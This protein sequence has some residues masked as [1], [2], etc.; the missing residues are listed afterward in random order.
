MRFRE[1]ILCDLNRS[2]QSLKR[3]E[4]FQF[5][6]ALRQVTPSVIGIE[7]LPEGQKDEACT[8]DF[9]AFLN[10]D[11]LQYQRTL[12]VQR[13]QRNP[14]A[15]FL[16]L[17]YHIVWN[18]P[19]RKPVFAHPA[20]EINILQDAFS[21][22]T[23]LVGGFVSLLWLAPDHIHLYVESDGKNSIDAVARKLKRVS[24]TALNKNHSKRELFQK[25]DRIIW[26]NVYFVETIG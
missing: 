22:C 19:A 4:C 9:H 1:E 17:K 7:T 20:D 18:V 26:D 11:R 2:A 23:E 10:S 5:R 24:K 15:V 3:F 16:D 13:L 14:D 6:P 25:A 21:I 8:D 12:A